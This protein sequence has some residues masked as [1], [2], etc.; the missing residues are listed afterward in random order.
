MEH[1]TSG[2]LDFNSTEVQQLANAV[3]GPVLVPGDDAYEDECGVYNL[4]NPLRPSIVVGATSARDVQTAIRFAVQRNMPIAVKATGHQMPVPGDA[5]LLIT[6]SRMTRVRVDKAS[7]T[8]RVEAGVRWQQLLDESERHGLTA[9]AGSASDVGVVGY[10]LGGGQSP[11]RGRSLG[12]AADHVREI[13]LVTADGEIRTVSARVEAE[14]FW[15]LRGG[16]GNFG[17][18]TAIEIDLFPATG[19]YGGG[20]YYAGEHMA[21]VLQVWSE[22][23]PTLPEEMTSSVAV[24]RLPPLPELPDPLRGAF[25]LHVRIAYLGAPDEAERLIAPLRAI[26]DPLLDDLTE[27]P[28]RAIGAIHKDPPGPLPYYDR[29][30]S[31]RELGRETV[32]AL[33]ALTGP[34][35][36]CSLVSVEIRA[37]G[38]AFDRSPANGNA[39]PTRGVPFVAFAFG[40]GGPQDADDLRGQLN[41][42]FTGLE[43]WTGE[44]RMVNFLSADEAT[45]ADGMRSVYGESRY[46]RLATVKKL[47][48]PANFFRVNHNVRPAE[49]L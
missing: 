29:T 9:L 6:T 15:A 18:V 34:D 45:T 40:V 32:D 22:W 42:V 16:K 36:G 23:V 30:V 39:V 49:E 11:V 12:Y 24:Q 13:Q 37:L 4:N 5:A 1:I 20:L 17:V 14:L 28:D 33:V 31:L 46:A 27:R 48:D 44:R 25:V 7:R 8:A 19:F 10:I 21:E 26:A 35:S 3:A 2:R 41:K 43:P 38:G 47:Y